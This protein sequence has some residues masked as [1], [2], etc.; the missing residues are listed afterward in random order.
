MK[1]VGIGKNYVNDLADKPTDKGTPIIFTK[2]ESTLLKTNEGLKL[3]SISDEVWYEIEIAF[4]IG[5][6]CKDVNASEAFKYIDALALANDLTAKDVLSASREKKGPWAL[7]KG[8]DGATPM[9]EF[10]PVSNFED[11][12]NINFSLEINGEEKQNG[13][14]SLMIFTLAEVIEYV[15]SFMTLE[16]GDVILTG[17]PAHGVSTLKSGDHLIGKIE[18]KVELETRVL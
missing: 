11:V 3:P 7:A 12:M 4:R 9:G 14:T 2:P 17:T 1:I 18:G 6:K 15:S 13:N 5:E 8:F 10:I 16:P